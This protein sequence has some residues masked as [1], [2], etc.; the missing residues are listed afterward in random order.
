MNKEMPPLVLVDGSSYLY[1]AFHA[2]PQLTTSQGQPTGAVR[3]VI[4][5]IKRL[6]KDYPDADLAVVFDAKGKT[7]RDELFAEY[8]AQRPPMPDELRTQVE[9]I[10]AIIRAMGLPLLVV[11]GVEADDVIG[12][13]AVRAAAKGRSV[14]V[15][16][17]DK[18]MAQLVGP[19][20]TLVN[21]MTDTRLDVAGVE[22]RFGVPPHL[23]IDLLALMGDKVDNIPGVPGVGEKTALAL[24]QG[25]GGIEALYANLEKI[26][27]LSVRGAKSLPARLEKEAANARLSYQLATIKTDVEL[28]IDEGALKPGEPDADALRQLY[29]DLEFKS[30]LEELLAPGDSATDNGAAALR[31][32]TILDEAT[33]A[34]WLQKLEAAPLFAFDTETTS[35]NYMEAQIVGL[36]FAVEPGEAAYLPLGHDY[37][38][39]P[40]QLDRDSTLQRLKPLLENPAAHKVG[41]NLKYDKSVLAN[42]GIDLQGILYDTMLESYVLDAAGNRHDMDTLALKYLGQRTVHFEDVA[43]KGKQQ[44]TFNQVNLED[45]APYAAEDAEVTL[46]LHQTLWPRVKAEAGLRAVFEELEIPL[47]SVLSRVERNGAL[48][49]RTRL[50]QQS[51]ELGER[52]LALETKAHELAGQPF[53]LCSPRQL[54]VS[55]FEQQGLP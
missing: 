4:S 16:T 41:Q 30:W 20:V 54:G 14:V 9:P 26:P 19:H 46:R 32:I 45:A 36:C 31:C 24:L 48:V 11:D 44:L 40:A 17:G 5:M 10:H 1:R 2:L 34:A 50:A 35:L 25:I 39:A 28:S 38:G 7:F 37:M 43:G 29:Q 53:N 21:T 42:H 18:D 52:L 47:V 13:L 6:Q 55:L 23:I 8:K 12:T 3:G 51:R 49:S 33:L 27:E 15:S 22:E